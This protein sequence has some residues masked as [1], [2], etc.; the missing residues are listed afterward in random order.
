[1]H[2]QVEGWNNNDFGVLYCTVT[3]GS[4]YSFT[5]QRLGVLNNRIKKDTLGEHRSPPSS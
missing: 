5:E 3:S 4:R 1:M 2:I